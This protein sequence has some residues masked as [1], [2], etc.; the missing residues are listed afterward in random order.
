MS[1]GSL[2]YG[3]ATSS[4]I[5]NYYTAPKELKYKWK[6]LFGNIPNHIREQLLMDRISTFSITNYKIA[7][8]MSDILSTLKDISKDSTILDGT[9]CIGG[10]TISFVKKRF[11][12]ISVELNPERYKILL[13]NLTLCNM[14]KKVKV[15]N[16]NLLDIYKRFK[17]DVIF[18]DPPW[19]GIEYVEKESIDLYLDKIELAEV[20]FKMKN[21]TTYIAIKTPI[22][23]N[24]TGFKQKIIENNTRT[25]KFKCIVKKP[26]DFKKMLLILIHIQKL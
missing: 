19:G 15:Y 1:D 26:I 7:D 14:D 5:Y 13:H 12:V 23:F 10:N 3:I 9:A 2:G 4:T 22:N 18:M 11:N 16:K 20:C 6:Y 8:K 25:K 17:V 24:Y 21:Y